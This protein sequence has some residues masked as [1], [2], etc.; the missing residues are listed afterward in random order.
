MADHGWSAVPSATCSPHAGRAAEHDVVLGLVPFDILIDE[1]NARSGYLGP[2]G[3]GLL[4]EHRHCR[5]LASP[6]KGDVDREAYVRSLI[7]EAFQMNVG[8]RAEI[9]VA[10][11]QG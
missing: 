9:A 4:S 2:S 11:E 10:E 3:H 5:L 8:W 7:H 1:M 6:A